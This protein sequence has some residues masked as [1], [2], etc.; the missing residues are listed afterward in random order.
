[1]W[2]IIYTR[3]SN[4]QRLFR[5]AVPR[6]SLTHM[7]WFEYKS[8]D[9]RQRP[10]IPFIPITRMQS[11]P[12]C[13]RRN[14]QIRFDVGPANRKNHRSK[15]KQSQKWKVAR[16]QEE[17]QAEDNRESSTKFIIFAI[18][19][20]SAFSAKASALAKFIWSRSRANKS[21]Q[22]AIC[23]TLV[24]WSA[25]WVGWLVV[26]RSGGLGLERR[27]GSEV[28]RHPSPARPHILTLVPM[29]K[30]RAHNKTTRKLTLGENFRAAASEFVSSGR[31]P[32]IV[33]GP[34]TH[35]HIQIPGRPF[36]S[37]ADLY[38]TPDAHAP[39]RS[40]VFGGGPQF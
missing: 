8:I 27:Q 25:A 19:A 13:T 30:S 10:T 34:H 6:K 17:I 35:T 5:N 37:L 23:D 1:M 21:W 16:E 24:Y 15:Q 32:R 7:S 3:F 39:M 31:N 12:E 28:H 38:A 2:I 36:K 33:Y 11:A 26:G 29:R 14:M 40:C 9:T 18:I 4:A 22:G 20:G